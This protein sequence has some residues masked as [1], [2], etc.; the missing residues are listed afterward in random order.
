M[1][2]TKIILRPMWRSSTTQ[3]II[4]RFDG[5]EYDFYEWELV[6]M[7]C[8]NF[9]ALI[10]FAQQSTACDSHVRSAWAAELTCES[11]NHAHY[12]KKLKNRVRVR[13]GLEHEGFR[14]IIYKKVRFVKKK[15]KIIS[16]F[17]SS[18]IVFVIIAAT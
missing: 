2:N 1:R 9:L 10:N 5:Y 12:L 13:V 15:K 11:R 14:T 3:R 4:V 17:V 18:S 16:S 7:K 8:F 6:V